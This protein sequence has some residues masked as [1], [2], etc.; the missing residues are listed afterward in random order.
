MLRTLKRS[1]GCRRVEVKYEIELHVRCPYCS[2]VVPA[3]KYC[4]FCGKRISS[5]GR[6]S[7]RLK[8]KRK[9][10]MIKEAKTRTV[11]DRLDEL[12]K[13]VNSILKIIRRPKGARA[14]VRSSTLYT[15]MRQPV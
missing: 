12:E 1:S 15:R 11:F 5:E 10:L 14:V 9:P 7:P 2:K 3:G 6:P 8:V 4:I 13:E